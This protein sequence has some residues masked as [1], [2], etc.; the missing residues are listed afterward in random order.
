LSQAARV[1]RWPLA[2]LPFVFQAAP[3]R[4]EPSE[5]AV[6][7]LYTAPPAC[8][9]VA[10]FTARVRERTSRGRL[11]E[12]G[13]LA[14]TFSIEVAAE[15]DGFAGDIAFLDDGG[16]KVAR[17][18]HGEQCD[19]VVSSLALITA[20]ALDATLRDEEEPPPASTPEKAPSPV[21]PRPAR[22][23]PETTAPPPPIRARALTGARIGVA[24]GYGSLLHALDLGLAPRLALLGQLDWRAGFSLRLSA[25]YDWHDVTV[26]EGRRAQLRLLGVETSAC[27]W[28]FHEAELAFAPCAT[29]DLGSLRAQGE[30]GDN[31]PKPDGKTI[32][33]AAVGGELRLAWEPDAPFWVELRAA[34]TFPLVATHRFRFLNPTQLVY[35][36]PWLTGA[37][38]TAVGVRFW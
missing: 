22:S 26:D 2:L 18:L 16:T 19:A 35:E 37:G 12:P 5:E 4:A 33:W 32:L 11:A 17:H 6:R 1:P 27:P 13:E 14:R 21:A 10:V 31:L 38:S 23:K 3:L 20:L 25:H 24:G 36:V 8:P 28:R 29:L 30:L 9:D 7:F 34:A 15:A